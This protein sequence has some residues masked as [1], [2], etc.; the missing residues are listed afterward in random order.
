MG[1]EIWGNKDM[2]QMREIK[3]NVSFLNFTIKMTSND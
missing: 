1:T 2:Y 3:W